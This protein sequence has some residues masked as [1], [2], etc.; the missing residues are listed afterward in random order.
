MAQ[1]KPAPQKPAAAAP[2]PAAAKSA[3][4]KIVVVLLVA[5]ASF[6]LLQA[7]RLLANHVKSPAIVQSSDALHMMYYHQFAQGGHCYYARGDIQHITDGYTP[8]A[9]E[10]F[11]LV[12]RIMG[13]DI[14]WVRLMAGLFGALALVL[15]GACVRR[16]TGSWLY[17]YIAAGLAAGLETGWYMQVGPDTLLTALALLAL[18]LLLRDPS[19]SWRTMW[20]VLA[21]LFAGFWTKQT[22]LGY[23][24]AGAFY[25]FIKDWRKGLAFIVV[26]GL[27][28][29][30]AVSH[31]AGLEGSRFTYWV[32]EMNRNQPIIWA[33]L[34]DPLVAKLLAR[35]YVILVS[36]I[37]AGLAFVLR[38]WRDCIRPEFVFLGAAGVAGSVASC[39]YGSG[40][41]QL[42]FLYTML[43][44]C[45]VSL[46]AGLVKEGRLNRLVLLLLLCMQGVGLIENIG[47]DFITTED[48]WRFTQ[49]LDILKTPGKSAC[50]INRG[51]FGLLAGKGPYPQAGEDCWVNGVYRPDTLSAERRKFLESD[52]W[53]IVIIDV[54]L[55]DGSF[56]LYERLNKSYKPV[57]E[58]PAS[59]VNG[60][61]YDIRWKKVIFER[62]TAPTPPINLSPG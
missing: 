19:A 61:R 38:S 2:P 44:L 58:I 17:A 12:I 45:G 42:F 24:A 47:P 48:Q 6:H 18:W 59:R 25:F 21:A 39:K 20:L 31:Y 46:G 56:L 53:D 51:Y 32:F 62:Q 34:W 41:S 4:E 10:I 30:V 28:T 23:L 35:K 29:A 7:A 5:L 50:Y 1:N 54:P 3:L 8:L 9:S 49:I 36:L 11:G 14:R 40:T 26:A 15:I 52:P 43:T 37:A 16:L 55:E 13:E 60:D 22:G 33:R 27:A 57:R